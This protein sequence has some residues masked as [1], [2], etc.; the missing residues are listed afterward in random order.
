MKIRD[1]YDRAAGEGTPNYQ[2]SS[3]WMDRLVHRPNER[4]VRRQVRRSLRD[5]ESIADL[6][7]GTGEHLCGEFS[8]LKRLFLNDL[9]SKMLDDTSDR[10]RAAHV[11]V[12]VVSHLGSIETIPA[13]VQPCEVAI[14]LGVLNHFEPQPL[15]DALATLARLAQKTIVLYY[16]HEG[17]LLAGKVGVSFREMD[18]HYRAIER[19]RVVGS[20]E[21]SG[22]ALVR[23]A[24]AFRLPILSPLVVQ[25][26]RAQ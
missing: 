10:L 7:C 13:D 26:F 12:D 6:G 20:L 2:E 17:F 25:E 4:F 9:S 3:A 21:Q 15:R 1:Y 22:F 11:G 24:Y 14:C 16:A 23:S 5:A 18:I 8:R 19:A